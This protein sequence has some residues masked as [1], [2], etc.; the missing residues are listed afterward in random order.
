MKIKAFSSQLN[1]KNGLTLQLNEN[2][3]IVVIGPNNS[4]KSATLKDILSA[5]RDGSPG[6]VLENLT[7]KRLTPLSEIERTLDP[8]LGGSGQVT[9]GGHSFPNMILPRWWDD[10]NHH[11]GPFL[12]ERM[13]SNLSTRERLSDCDP[14]NT[15]DRTKPFSATHP[16]QYFF[17]DDA[18]ESRASN[19]FRR[20]FKKDMIIHR[21]ASVN[22]PA[23]IG[24][25]PTLGP[26]EDRISGSYLDRLENLDRLET[27]GDGMRSFASILGRTLADSKPILLIDEPEA[28]LHP[29]QARLIADIISAESAERQTFIATHSREVLQGLLGSHSARVSVV[30][31]TRKPSGGS[32][33]H[34]PS[35]D[36]AALWKDPILRFSNVLDGLF[37]EVVVVT[38]ADADC[39]FYEALAQ[40]TTP[41]G[42]L[43][44]VHYTY[45]GGKDRLPIVVKSL[46]TLGVPVATIADFDLLN[47]ET[48]LSL[49][50]E[51]HGGD[52]S[53]IKPNWEAVKN[54]IEQNSNFVGSDQFKIQI[55]AI[56]KSIPGGTAV[57]KSVLAKIKNL[58]RNASAWDHAK[59]SGLASLPNGEP[60]KK[61]KALLA[62]LN[63]IGVFVVPDGEMEG[64]CR[65]VSGHGPRWVE[66]VMKLDLAADTTLTNARRFIGEIVSHLNSKLA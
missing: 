57:E 46:R 36:I 62:D 43:P 32:A 21:G 9:V 38:E 33:V 14:A 47:N 49:I 64:F 13:I 44:D 1:F 4:G 6:I 31:L 19:L 16:F 61:A 60:T 37:H 66:E 18:L 50:V 28:F 20:A 8:Y 59:R 25:R 51:A 56:I 22:I 23:Y 3:I 27:Q 10:S 42:Q 52:W 7:V 29:P 53:V 24:D 11:V 63:A 39:R 48:P 45:S 40:S 15:F 35:A 2:D 65:D 26:N 41:P 58:A 30:R 54:T 12:A 34:L 5:L 55:S 17:K